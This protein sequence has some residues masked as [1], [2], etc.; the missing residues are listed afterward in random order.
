MAILSKLCTY[1]EL[2]MKFS[3]KDLEDKEGYDSLGNAPHYKQFRIDV[4][5]MIER[6]WGTE[7]TMTFCEMNAFKYRM[8]LGNKVTQEISKEM[9]KVGWYERAAKELFEKLG[10][11]EEIKIDNREK[12]R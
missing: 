12:T 3:G 9:V 8:R 5:D 1:D 10:T 7:H 6:V 11:C 2:S 4:I